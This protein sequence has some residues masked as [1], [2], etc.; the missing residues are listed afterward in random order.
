[1]HSYNYLAWI[2]VVAGAI[3]GIRV[4][5]IFR[6]ETI[7]ISDHAAKSRLPDVLNLERLL[8][9][10]FGSGWMLLMGFVF[11]AMS[12][13]PIR[14]IVRAYCVSCGAA[15]VASYVLCLVQM[16]RL[17]IFAP[18]PRSPSK[19][20]SVRRRPPPRA[21]PTAAQAGFAPTPPSSR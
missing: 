14:E 7:Q 19:R 10:I 2:A 9:L 3:T 5:A 1:M 17:G 6:K 4:F 11:A 16:H 13:A 12:P 20:A 21:T 18:A 8:F 15:I